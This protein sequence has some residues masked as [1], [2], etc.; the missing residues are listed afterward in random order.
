MRSWVD[1]ETFDPERIFNIRSD[2]EFV[3][4][5]MDLFRFQAK[6]VPPYAEYVRLLGVDPER[7][8][9]LEEIPFLPISF[10]KS[11]E[12][13][14]ARKEPEKI[15]TSSSTT[16]QTPARHYVA[17]LKLYERA[18]TEAFEHF[19]GPVG[20]VSIFA[21]LPGYLERE[22][23]SLI[24][25]VD[26]LIRQGAGGG[27]YLY[28]H[29]ALL[30]DME[31][32]RGKKI[33]LGVS[34]A[35]WDLAEQHPVPLSDTIVMETGG[36]KGKRQE[37]SK[38]EFHS[39]LCEA[40]SVPAIHSE[41]GMAELMSQ[42]YSSGQGI[43]RTPPWM[44]VVIRDLND[45]FSRVSAE[46]TGGVNIIDLANVWSCAFIQTDDLGSVGRDGSFRML[47]RITGSE[48]RGCNL[49]VQ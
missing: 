2:E 49:L 39:L 35:L 44:R 18:F 34:Y 28:D 37:L 19:Y 16:G 29:E 47:G 21:L 20:E 4:A 9:S 7:V 41:Y 22:G 33:L 10:F 46:R 31:A 30:R 6:A 25:M 14:G 42:A 24:Y 38:E 23:S 45:P 36:M 12:V 43:F 15:F 17:D 40:F 1:S 27:F 11:R 26:H 5:A 13:Y 32:C 8:S 48:I 3:A